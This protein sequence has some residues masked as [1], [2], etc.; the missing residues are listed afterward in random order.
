MVGGVA[1]GI[2]QICFAFALHSVGM[3][4]AFVLNIGIGTG[5]EGAED[6]LG[7]GVH[8]KDDDLRIRRTLADHSSGL[9]AV[10]LGHGDVH[11]HHIWLEPGNL[12]GGIIAAR[13]LAHDLDPALRLE[14]HAQA[15][16]DHC[17]VV[18]NEDR[19]A[20]PSIIATPGRETRTSSGHL[21]VSGY[22]RGSERHSQLCESR[23][24]R[25]SHGII[26][27]Q[28]VRAA[29]LVHEDVVGEVRPAS[30]DVNV[31]DQ[32]RG[33]VASGLYYLADHTTHQSQTIS[34]L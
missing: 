24:E 8:R 20:H 3:G 10:E 16:T 18:G 14:Q 9:D 6:V 23:P 34:D 21:G 13:G 25:L 27:G 12:A 11:E 29:P 5:L 15:V 1:F 31:V 30:L 4:L 7:V 32:L 19:D 28:A 33:L 17:V 2:G 22:T 26:L